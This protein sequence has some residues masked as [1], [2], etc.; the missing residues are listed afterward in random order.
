MLQLQYHSLVELNFPNREWM[1]L[2]KPVLPSEQ[3]T[4]A[5]DFY[6]LGVKCDQRSFV[7]TRN[8]AAL[9]DTNQGASITVP[10]LFFKPVDDELTAYLTYV[11]TAF[12]AVQPLEVEWVRVLKTLKEQFQVDLAKGIPA[13]LAATLA[14]AGLEAH[15][16]VLANRAKYTFLTSLELE[17]L[18][19]KKWDPSVFELFESISVEL[20][21]AALKAL[22]TWSISAA[23]AKDLLQSLLFLSRKTSAE[24]AI[25]ILSSTYKTGDDLRIAIFHSAQPEL[26]RLSRERIERLRALSVPPRTSV[27]GDPSFESDQLKISHNPKT[28]GDFEAFKQWVSDPTTTE[29]LRQLLEIYQ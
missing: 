23:N 19:E 24:T 16:G 26:A 2:R 17:F 15:L 11:K 29:R 13:L 7:W 12:Q 18:Y 8:G 3:T 6:L 25:K 9:T 10:V 21:E 28:I 5:P 27:F 4:G 14:N 20:R 22:Q 1:W